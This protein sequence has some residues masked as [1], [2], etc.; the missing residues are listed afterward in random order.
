[1]VPVCTGETMGYISD[2]IYFMGPGRFCI[3][4]HSVWLVYIVCLY[5]GT[6]GVKNIL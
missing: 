5:I 2:D 4:S 6:L 1:M 3:C